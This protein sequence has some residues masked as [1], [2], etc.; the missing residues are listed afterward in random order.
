MSEQ[1]QLE[2]DDE[3]D[4]I[5]RVRA[6]ARQEQFLEVVTAEVAR[7]R[8]AQAIDLTPLSGVTVPLAQALQL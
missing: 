4:L 6:A 5:A 2:F 3:A 8:F 7:E 1:S